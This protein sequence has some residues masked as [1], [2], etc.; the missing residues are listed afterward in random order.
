MNIEATVYAALQGLVSGRVYPD[1]APEATLRPYLTYQKIGGSSVNFLD[2]APPGASNA[3]IQV[4]VWADTRGSAAALARIVEDTLRAAPG[5]QM[6]VEGGPVSVYEPD[7]R[8]RGSMQ[9]FSFWTP[10]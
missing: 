8:L 10:D 2:Q 6:T 9:D 7:T 3:R 4:N 1:V 5:L